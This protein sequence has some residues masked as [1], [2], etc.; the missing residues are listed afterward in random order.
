MRM[1]RHVLVTMLLV[2][3]V[4]SPFVIAGML[5]PAPIDWRGLRS[6]ESN[7]RRF[8]PAERDAAW[9]QRSTGGRTE[10]EFLAQ[11]EKLETSATTPN[12]RPR[13]G[14]GYGYGY[15]EYGYGGRVGAAMAAQQVDVNVG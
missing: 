2:V 9:N 5:L 7:V 6:E 12:G 4:A 14:R 13:Y 15:G 1:S 3:L 8:E 11:Y 10:I